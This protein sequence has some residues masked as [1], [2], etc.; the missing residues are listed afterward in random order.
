MILFGSVGAFAATV[1][2]ADC[3]MSNGETFTNQCAAQNVTGHPNDYFYFDTRDT[4]DAM[5]IS[6]TIVP[7]ILYFTLPVFNL[8]MDY[9]LINDVIATFRIYD[10]GNNLLE[11]FNDDALGGNKNATHNWAGAD[12]ARLEFFGNAGV[13]GVSTLRFDIQAVPEPASLVLLLAGT[14]LGL[15]ARRRA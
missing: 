1:T 5:G 2:F 12:I 8:S 14:V 15:A 7:G 4:F 6:N 9:V 13:I 11:T 3:G 10:S